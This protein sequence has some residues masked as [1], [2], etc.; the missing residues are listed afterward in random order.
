ME[1]CLSGKW[2]EDGEEEGDKLY[3]G[4]PQGRKDRDVSF[5]RWPMRLV[6]K[7]NRQRKGR[8]IPS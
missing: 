8:G 2:K 7:K 3:T 6:Q 5:F 1:D 4:L